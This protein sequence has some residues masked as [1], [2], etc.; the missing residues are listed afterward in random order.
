MPFNNYPYTNLNDINL[1]AVLKLAAEAKRLNEDVYTYIRDHLSEIA[2]NALYRA[3]DK[4]LVLGGSTNLSPNDVGEI[5]YIQLGDDRYSLA[6][7]LLRNTLNKYVFIGDSWGAGYSD[8][9]GG[10]VAGWT[11]LLRSLMGLTLGTDCY[12]IARHGAAV[13]TL[14]NPNFNDVID[15]EISNI[16]VSERAK[17][18]HVIFGASLNDTYDYTF[19]SLSSSIVSF[20]AKVKSYFPNAELHMIPLG[21]TLEP[22]RRK[23]LRSVVSGYAY[24]GSGAGWVVEEALSTAVTTKEYFIN[25]SHVNSSGMNIIARSIYST[26]KGGE[27]IFR[28]RYTFMGDIKLSIPNGTQNQRLGSIEQYDGYNHIQINGNSFNLDDVDMAAYTWIKIGTIDSNGIAGVMSGADNENILRTAVRIRYN[29][30][31]SN[32]FRTVPCSIKFVQ[33]T[34]YN[35]IDMYIRIEAVVENA[36]NGNQT[37]IKVNNLYFGFL[38]SMISAWDF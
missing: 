18:T 13:N 34:D 27:S 12:I 38:Y 11:Y 16:P 5:E 23:I 21:W 14:H 37:F 26:L 19:A 8:G 33:N 3:G 4:T 10:T 35:D 22:D 9:N 20:T 25:S 31:G 1:D 15:S 2:I 36:T 30:S 29:P 32:I 24:F 6:D 28:S 7:L 17:I